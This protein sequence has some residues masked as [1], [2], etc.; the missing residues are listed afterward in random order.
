[1]PRSFLIALVLCPL[2]ACGG[3]SKAPTS[4]ESSRVLQGQAI[5]GIDR[6]GIASVSVQVGSRWPVIAD[7]N[8]MFNV[9]LESSGSHRV[10][11]KGGAVVERETA[12]MAPTSDRILLPLIPA[13]F[14]LTAFDEMFRSSNARLQRWLTRPSLIVLGAVM[15]Y[16]ANPGSEFEATAESLTDTDTSLMV[17]HLSEGLALLTGETFT[18]FASVSVERPSPGQRVNVN[19]NGYIVAGR[20][21]GIASMANTIGYGQWSELSNG[22]VVGGSIFLDRDF[23]TNDARRRLLRMHELGHA[24]GY[25]H[26]KA[27]TSIMNA[28]V[29]P[30]PTD[31]DRAAARLAFQRA[32]GNRAPDI[33]P[34][35]AATTMSVSGEGGRWMPPVFCK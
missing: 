6:A 9:D 12:V 28:A 35:S 1:M 27:R 2:A 5:N 29:G 19:R 7:D 4:P 16:R 26:V 24:L 11:V 33:D 34:V 14:D 17:A 31:F 15:A 21:T 10:T 8:G 18:G 22:T 25:L 32:P 20:Y 23:D 13:S 30:E 3:S